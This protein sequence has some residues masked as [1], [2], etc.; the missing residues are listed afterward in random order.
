MGQ[1]QAAPRSAAC[2]DHQATQRGPGSSPPRIATPGFPLF[3]V[4]GPGSPPCPAPAPLSPLLRFRCGRVP[5]FPLPTPPPSLVPSAPVPG[6]ASLVRSA[7]PRPR[8]LV[9]PEP[10]AL[11]PTAAAPAPLL[12]QGHVDLLQALA[13]ALPGPRRSRGARERCRSPERVHGR[14]PQIG[15]PPAGPAHEQQLRPAQGTDAQAGQ[16]RSSPLAPRLLAAGRSRYSGR[17]AMAG[18]MAGPR[19]PAGCWRPLPGV[20]SPGTVSLRRTSGTSAW[21]RG[22]ARG[23]GKQSCRQGAGGWG[24]GQLCRRTR[25]PELAADLTSA[26]RGHGVIGSMEH[27]SYEHRLRDLGGFSL[28]K[29]KLREIS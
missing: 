24:T 1:T 26:E 6:T 3:P 2:S 4:T 20:A 21:A 13:A 5:F 19:G 16:R 7:P 25:N 27:L 18:A 12:T 22:V 23:A 14:L 8:R 17:G 11:S 28:K 9:Q 10:S 15:P 29:R